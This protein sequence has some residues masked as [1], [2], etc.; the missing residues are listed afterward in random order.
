MDEKNAI[1]MCLTHNEG[2]SIV[3]K[4]F[5]KTLKNKIYKYMT[6]ASKNMYIDKSHDI[7]N[8]YNNTCHIIIKIRP[9]DVKSNTYIN[10]GKEI[11]NK[12]HKFKI[13]DIVRISEYKNIFANRQVPSWSEE[14]FV[15]RKNKNT[16]PWKIK[17]V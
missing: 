1:E 7:V 17:G 3:T 14:V 13:R 4:R 10:S 15:I 5:I 12:D 16:V 11:N 8:K 6:S 9:V 2:K